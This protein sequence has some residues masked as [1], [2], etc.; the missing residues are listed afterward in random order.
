MPTITTT[1][2]PYPDAT[3]ARHSWA[4]IKAIIAGVPFL[5]IKKCTY[6]RKR[7]REEVR[8]TH[9]D[10]LGKTVGENAYTCAI[11]LYLAE[12]NQ[13][14]ALIQDAAD[15]QSI[16]DVGYGDVFFTIQVQYSANGFDTIQDEIIGCTLDMTSADQQQGPS[17]LIRGI[18]LNPLKILFNGLDDVL[19]SLTAPAS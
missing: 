15:Q 1:P 14:Q 8:G 11:D 12:W 19:P 13:L 18:E 6:D 5:G 17:A 9:V 16:G 10:P 3:G 7:T 4:S 2:I